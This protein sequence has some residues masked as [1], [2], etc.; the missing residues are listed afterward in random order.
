MRD[1]LL[2]LEVLRHIGNDIFHPTV[3]AAVEAYL[4][5]HGVDWTP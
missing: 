2:R 5:D 3:G 1:K 4:E